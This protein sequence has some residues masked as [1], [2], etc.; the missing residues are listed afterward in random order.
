MLI[1]RR[2]VISA[3]V[4]D[5][6]LPNAARFDSGR[7]LEYERK[8]E[9]DVPEHQN[10]G[11]LRTACDRRRDSRL[12]APVRTEAERSEAAF[13]RQRGC[14]QSRT[15]RGDRAAQRLIRSLQTSAPPRTREAEAHKATERARLRFG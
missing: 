11:Q 12:G 4:T 15:G 2:A 9:Q 6:R 8:E 5:R 13:A 7:A 3:S 10:A 14:L 1:A